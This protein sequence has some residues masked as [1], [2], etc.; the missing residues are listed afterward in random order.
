MP[1]ADGE[2]PIQGNEDLLDRR[3]VLLAA[4]VEEP[5]RHLDR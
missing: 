2:I 1:E 5:E 4:A 3:Q